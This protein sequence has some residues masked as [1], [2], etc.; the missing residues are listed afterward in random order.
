[1]YSSRYWFD[2]QSTSNLLISFVKTNLLIGQ[3]VTWNMLAFIMSLRLT[4]VSN[5]ILTK[6]LELS[7]YLTSSVF[8]KYEDLTSLYEIPLNLLSMVILRGYR[9]LFWNCLF[10]LCV[11]FTLCNA[12]NIE[13]ICDIR[14]IT[15]G[16]D[17][18]KQQHLVKTK[19]FHLDRLAVDLC[20]TGDM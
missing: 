2:F 13:M 5:V 20:L 3:L 19:W 1:M 14:I 7:T 17:D 12:A 15:L 9:K 10:F 6:P 16:E 4:A 11:Q 8:L 18:G